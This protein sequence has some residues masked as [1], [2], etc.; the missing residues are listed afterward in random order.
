MISP[1]LEQDSF[2]RKY[3]WHPIIYKDFKSK[4]ISWL[5]TEKLPQA[6]KTSL[7]RSK[8]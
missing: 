3:D 2:D 1:G 5:M 6:M 7:I 8:I 4:I